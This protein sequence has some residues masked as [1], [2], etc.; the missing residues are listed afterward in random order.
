MY[1]GLVETHEGRN[2]IEGIADR[3]VIDVESDLM[4]TP[5]DKPVS[6]VYSDSRLCN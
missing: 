2:E 5:P 3:M 1:L 6:E 4:H